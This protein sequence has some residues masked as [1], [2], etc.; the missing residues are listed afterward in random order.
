MPANSKRDVAECMEKVND[1]LKMLPQH[2]DESML[3]RTH[4]V[5]KTLKMVLRDKDWWSV[6]PLGL[7]ELMC[8]KIGKNYSTTGYA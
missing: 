1:V 5:G 3:S 7:P 2:V 4:R 8:T 6:S